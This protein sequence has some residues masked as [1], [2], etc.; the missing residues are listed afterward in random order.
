MDPVGRTE[1]WVLRNSLAELL[2][3]SLAEDG[4][5]RTVILV[6]MELDGRNPGDVTLESV[7]RT[8]V[9]IEDE[10]WVDVLMDGPRDFGEASAERW[11]LPLDT[12]VSRS[13]CRTDPPLGDRV[14]R[15][16]GSSSSPP[17]GFPLT[18]M[19]SAGVLLTVM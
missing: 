15:W 19:R 11:E 2:R 16:R 6:G 7:G 18:L 14:L 5:A 3:N 1:V 9:R 8:D 10:L 4:V 13:D 17:C 12:P